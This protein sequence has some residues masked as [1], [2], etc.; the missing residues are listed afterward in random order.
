MVGGSKAYRYRIPRATAIRS[1]SDKRMS[2]AIPRSSSEI[3]DCGTPA[4]RLSSRCVQPQEIRVAFATAQN[5][6]KTGR[7]PLS[8]VMPACTTSRLPRPAPALDRGGDQSGDVRAWWRAICAGFGQNLAAATLVRGETDRT[9]DHAERS[10]EPEP[11]S[12]ARSEHRPS[13]ILPPCGAGDAE[14]ASGWPRNG[15]A[16]PDR[17]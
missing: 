12:R 4:R 2:R 9:G 13:A 8:G 1:R 5:V 11:G 17:R 15:A 14:R 6:A 16:D 10:H 7:I 3:S